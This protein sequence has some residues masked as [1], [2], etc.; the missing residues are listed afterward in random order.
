VSADFP[1]GPGPADPSLESLFRALTADGSADELAGRR[2]ALA[3]FRRNRRRPRRRTAFPIGT[4]AAAVLIAGGITAA[5][6]AVLP[7]PV[8]HIAFRMLNG[9]GVPD[10]HHRP[11]SPSAPPVASSLP[12]TTSNSANTAV[13]ASATAPAAATSACRCRSVTP[14]PNAPPVLVL[15]AASARI[16]A[17]GD[18]VLSGRLASGGRAEPGVGLWL[19]EHVAGR[20]GWQVAGSAVTDRNG[21]VRLTVR[22]L[23]SNAS[24]RLAAP[25]G[26]PSVPVLITV[27]PPVDLHLAAGPAAGTDTLTAAAAFADA[28]DVVVLQ[29]LSGGKWHRVGERELGRDLLASFTVK[30]PASGGH[31]YRV[32]LPP[33]I[34]HSWSASGQV[35]VAAPRSGRPHSQADRV[36]T[37]TSRRASD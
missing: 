8:Q 18:A 20:R 17:D 31:V 15:T 36:L 25:G 19:F 9:I 26:P 32:V 4:A 30:V 11:P 2:A 27:I 16:P 7:A 34:S 5:Y 37:R 22:S 24:F 33:T 6:A 1:D 35:R 3:M 23:T 13:S 14:S 29:E 10:A 12:A 28:G 21:E